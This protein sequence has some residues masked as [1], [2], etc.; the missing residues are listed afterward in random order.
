MFSQAKDHRLSSSHDV[1]VAHA[2]F[3]GSR[4]LHNATNCHTDKDTEDHLSLTL[5][6]GFPAPGIVIPF[7]VLFLNNKVSARLS[8]LVQLRVWTGKDTRV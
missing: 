4:Q 7:P 3:E 8:L 6:G 2:V 5:A 1:N